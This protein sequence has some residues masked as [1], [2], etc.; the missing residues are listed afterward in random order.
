MAERV[1]AFGAAVPVDD[2]RRGVPTTTVLVAL[3]D[4][5]LLAAAYRAV[6]GAAPDLL[7]AGVAERRDVVASAVARFAA[8]IVV[9][10]AP[11]STAADGAAAATVAAI[12]AARAEARILAVELRCGPAPHAQAPAPWADGVLPR[13]ST[14]GDVLEA[15]RSLGRGEPWSAGSTSTAPP[16][17]DA[18]SEVREPG[19]P[20]AFDTLA[21]EAREV[22]RLAALGGSSREIARKLGT[23]EQVVHAQRALIMQRLGLHRRVELLRYALRRGII[24][25]TD[26]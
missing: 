4:V 19:R 13:G 21:E 24:R 9:I 8:D 11:S 5:P 23:S 2:A 18:A 3:V 10:D 1:A 15:L 7:V 17:A 6:I 16:A 14:P 26:L 20:D 25:A 22:L 12:R